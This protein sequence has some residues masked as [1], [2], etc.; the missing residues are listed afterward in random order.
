MGIYI[1]RSIIGIRNGDTRS[2]EDGSYY[3]PTHLIAAC[4]AHAPANRI[5]A[6]QMATFT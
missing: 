5:L 2:L 6:S 4:L 3:R 1:Y